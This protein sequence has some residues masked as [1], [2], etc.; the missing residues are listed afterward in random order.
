FGL[1]NIIGNFIS[2]LI[3]VFERPI[4]IGDV[5]VTDQVEGVVTEI[6]ARASKVRSWDGAEMVVPNM[7]FISSTITNWTLSDSTRR[8]SLTFFADPEANPTEVIQ[9][10]QQV[11]RKHPL[12]KRYPDPLVLYKG[13]RDFYN[14]FQA[15]F[16]VETE[17][18]RTDSEISSQVFEAM[19]EKGIHQNPNIPFMLK[20]RKDD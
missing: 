3:L 19:K 6:G 16:W 13:Y 15:L 1:Q 4:H 20:N 9:M 12:V 10:I 8:R 7:V 2:G 14:E 18:L 5:I 17:I 11:I